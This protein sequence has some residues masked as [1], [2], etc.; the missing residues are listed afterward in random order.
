MLLEL[1][2]LFSKIAGTRSRH[3]NLLY[4][5][6]LGMNNPKKEIYET[7]QFITASKRIHRK[8]FKKCKMCTCTRMVIINKISI[9]SW[10]THGEIGALIH[11]R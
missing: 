8:I 3:K 7:T 1:I 10:P 9:N 4:F 5:H 2:N 11:C 6:T